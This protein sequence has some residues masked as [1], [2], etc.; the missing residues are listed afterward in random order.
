MS[1]GIEANEVTTLLSE[2]LR[3]PDASGDAALARL[4]SLNY[5]IS[6]TLSVDVARNL[7]QA[8]IGWKA[9]RPEDFILENIDPRQVGRL[10]CFSQTFTYAIK[11]L[12]STNVKKE[13][14]NNFGKQLSISGEEWDLI[15]VSATN[16]MNDLLDDVI[17]N[18]SGADVATSTMAWCFAKNVVAMVLE[19]A[20]KMQNLSKGS[21]DSRGKE[22]VEEWNEFFVDGIFGGLLS[23]T[24][25]ICNSNLKPGTLDD[26]M[27]MRP[28]GCGCGQMDVN[29][30]ITTR[31]N[32]TSLLRS[33]GP[34]L[35]LLPDQHLIEHSLPAKFHPEDVDATV[36]PDKVVFLLN[37]L[38]PLIVTHSPQNGAIAYTLLK[39]VM[40]HI[41]QSES[42]KEESNED[43]GRG[44]GEDGP[45]E[46]QAQL[47]V[48]PRRL[49]EILITTEPLISAFLDEIGFDFGESLPPSLVPV[50]GSTST[51]G[52]PQLAKWFKSYLMTWRLVLQIVAE[53]NDVVRMKYS[54]CFRDNIKLLVRVIFHL[55]PA[56]KIIS[57]IKEGEV[58]EVSGLADLSSSCLYCLMRYLPAVVRSQWGQ[59]ERKSDS[60][61]ID[62]FT[63][64]HVT[65]VL[66]QEEVERI[67]T[68][69]DTFDNMTIKVRPNVR[70][71]VASYNFNDEGSMEVV[72][73]LPT[74]FPLGA[75]QVESTKKVGV[76]HTQWRNLMLQL[77]TFLQH[78][79]GSIVDGLSVWK[80][81]IDKRFEGVEECYICFFVLHGTNHQLPKAGCRTCKKKFHGACLYKWF[82]T[83]N[84]STCPLCRNLF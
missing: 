64:A 40:G 60:A 58:G 15:T 84:N 25:E 79:N 30:Y 19:L 69:R 48:L 56:R 52:N 81:N 68:K 20:D 27:W 42:S 76:T 53:A 61:I 73:Q 7:L 83:S 2:M 78:Q 39:R 51:A 63:T 49:A 32:G 36:L 22:L 47:G 77:T 67:T 34:L 59:M 13:L 10:V 17:T 29:E 50:S 6:E 21:E 4:V 75:V 54:D 66:W 71:V 65:P 31:L 35:K 46:V 11:C 80:R 23:R 41:A 33:M 12:L 70:E 57:D 38:C 82:Q 1:F 55:L 9:E 16:W 3:S 26:G 43:Y 62:K 45:E 72:I 44:T 8:L 37:H 18:A 24:L 74:N 5:R 14:S 28:S